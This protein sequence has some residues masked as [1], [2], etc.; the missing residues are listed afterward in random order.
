MNCRDR[1]MTNPQDHDTFVEGEEDSNLQ[2]RCLQLNIAAAEVMK[3][4][5]EH[6]Y[7]QFAEYLGKKIL[8]PE[9]TPQHRKSFFQQLKYY[10]WEDPFL[11]KECKDRITRRCVV[12]YCKK[13]ILRYGHLM[14][15]DDH[16]GWVRTAS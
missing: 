16:N 3:T 14:T 8:P 13:D 1:K 15:A 2:L 9:I 5:A 6:W 12:D 10:T 11:F 4:S 7:A